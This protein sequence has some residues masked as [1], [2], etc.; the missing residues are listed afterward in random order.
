MSLATGS[1]LGPYEVVALLGAGGM[2]EVYRARDT[3]LNRDVAIK[4]LPDLFAADPERLARFQREAQVLASLNHPNI[5]HIHGLEE[6]GAV[7]GLVM[8]LVEGED[9]AQRL[10]RGPIALTEALPIARQIAEALEAAHEQG[11]I[12][13]DLKPANIKVRD[14]GT[15]KVLDFGL[16]KALDAAPSSSP[17]VTNSP[18]LSLQATQAGIILGTAAYMAPEQAHGR[19]ADRR[20]DIFSFGAVLFE[21][22]SGHQAFRGE[23]ISDTLAS[24]LKLDPDWQQLPLDTPGSIRTLL[25]RCLTKDR[26]QRLQAIGEARIVLA[27]PAIDEPASTAGTRT[28]SSTPWMIAAALATI[29]AAVTTWVWL[30]PRPPAK[31]QILRF[32]TDIAVANVEGSVALSPD[33]ALLAFVAEPGRGIH[34][35]SLDRFSATAIPNTENAS[36]LSFSPDAQ[37]ISYI[38]GDSPPR[39]QLMKVA[40]SGGPVQKLADARSVAGPPTHAW[41]ADGNIIFTADG[42]LLRISSNGGQP[43]V[44]ATPD[45][46]NGERFYAAP[47]LLPSGDELLVSIISGQGPASRRVVAFNLANRRKKVLIERFGL[48]QFVPTRANSFS[49]HLVSYDSTTSALMAVPFD[50]NRLEV[51]GAPV[52]LLDGVRSAGA[53]GVFAVSGSG[54][55]AYVPGRSAA[56][57]ARAMVWVNR[58]GVEQ[59]SGAPTRQ[60]NL[61]RLSP[62]GQQVA[63]EVQDP[64]AGKADLWVYDLTRNVFTRITSEGTNISPVWMPDGRRLI[65][66]TS[67]DSSASDSGTGAA[68]RPLRLVSAPVDRSAPP[69]PLVGPDARLLPSS[70]APDG[71]AVI[72]YTIAP[73]SSANEIVAVPL[74]P[75]GAGTEPRTFPTSRFRKLGVVFSPDGRWVAFS[76]NDSG[77]SEIYVSA[78]PGPGSTVQISTDGGGVPRWRRDGRE[79]F[80]RSGSRTMAVAIQLEPAFRAGRPELLFEGTYQGF[81][82]APDGQR[83]LMVKNVEASAPQTDQLNFVVNWLEELKAR[84]RAK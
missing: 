21:I 11:I 48:A 77:R 40:V 25:R 73:M 82:V 75:P 80:Y 33:G 19:A 41:G 61:P 5:A 51:S 26:A 52:P 16:A 15:V 65:Y 3:K 76:A 7:R 18:T 38:A 70:V 14:D 50:A 2:G 68:S 42:S 67:A 84:V 45:V 27:Q 24:V 78:Y 56:N 66:A 58:Q 59:P 32:A 30:R 20:A 37:W 55:L 53:F 83:F 39:T 47:Q 62:D 60:Y 34:V 28:T 35:R 8:E 43:E 17:Q 57:A 10:A 72:G 44:L 13:R 6:S 71:T 29:V 36:F 54:M 74:V 22:L 64:E 46:R 49:G 81:D 31:Q 4:V 79:L 9:V 63:V 69:A 23:S 12:H 1:R